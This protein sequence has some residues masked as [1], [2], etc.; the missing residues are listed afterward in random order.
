VR[1]RV[2]APTLVGG[3]LVVLVAIATVAVAWLLWT[4]ADDRE[5]AQDDRAAQTANEAVQNSIGRVLTSLRASAGLVDARGNVDEASFEAFARAVG[6]IGGSSALALAEVVPAS[7]RARFESAFGRQISEQVGGG[8]FRAAG[9][10]PVYV[11]IVSVWPMTGARSALL[12]YDLMSE[13]IRRE[14]LLRARATRR[15]E[16]TGAIP[17]LAG[18][19]GYLALRPLYAPTGDRDVPVAYIGTWFG[20]GVVSGVLRRLPPELRVRLAIDGRQVY[21]TPD[22]PSGG[23]TR[24]FQLGGRPWRLTAQGEGVGHGSSLAILLGGAIL[25]LMLGAFTWTRATSERRLRSANEAERAARERSEALE[26]NAARL[27]ERADMLQR[28]AA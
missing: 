12:G 5:R 6:S 25:A 18:G 22:P 23:V 1:T 24:S 16:F 9:A 4:R 13:P 8:G 14:T 21:A 3:V 26:R 27:G 28:L 2:G 10:R 7:Q 20:M 11:P 19:R 17:F 15:T